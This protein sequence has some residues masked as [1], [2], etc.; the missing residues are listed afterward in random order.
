MKNLL[1]NIVLQDHVGH[2]TFL[3]FIIIQNVR[4]RETWITR[5]E[6]EILSA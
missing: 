2:E 6:K 4:K 1:T 5:K 3:I